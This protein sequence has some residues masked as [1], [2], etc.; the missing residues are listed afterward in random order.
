MARDARRFD[1]KTMLVGA[2]VKTGPKYFRSPKKQ[3]GEVVGW[4]FKE[5][6][7]SHF[8]Y[9]CDHAIPHIVV[10]HRLNDK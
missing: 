10:L 9:W 1:M 5:E 7:D 2:Q 3:K 6:D 4:W 8:E